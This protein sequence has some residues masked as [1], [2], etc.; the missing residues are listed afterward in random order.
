MDSLLT[1]QNFLADND[2]LLVWLGIFSALMFVGSVL[3]IPWILIRLP[4]DYFASPKRHSWLRESQ[5]PLL[6]LPLR[7]LKN[8][9]G[10]TL[11][12]LGI[13]LLVLPGQGLLTIV[14]GI[15][16]L[17]FPRKYKLESWLMQR[18]AIRQTANWLRQKYG[19]PPLR[20]SDS[21]SAF[22]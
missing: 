1:L 5:Y 12:L 13:I 8:F 16:L 14:I 20:F 9:A 11:V 10:I 15:V 17:D 2:V 4:A 18:K 7:L 3:I 22:R 19:R 6:Y 21:Q